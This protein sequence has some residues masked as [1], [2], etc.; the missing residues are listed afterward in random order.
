MILNKIIDSLIVNLPSPTVRNDIDLIL[1]GGAFRGSYTVGC[2]RVLK[3]IE[4]KHWIKVHRISGCSIGSIS[5]LL[6]LTDNLD[7]CESFYKGSRKHFIHNHNLEYGKFW[8]FNFKNKY[9][10]KKSYLTF[11]NRLL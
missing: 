5:A 2:L 6:Y 9:L 4:Q 3:H 8:L 11:N 10:K 1:D 7:L